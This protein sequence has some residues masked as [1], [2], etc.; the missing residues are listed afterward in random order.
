MGPRLISRGIE[1]SDHAAQ[2]G[3]AA[4]MGPRLISRGI[5]GV[6]IH[7]GDHRRLQWGRG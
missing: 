4:S 7:Q 2:D 6:T 3:V 1:I 5:E